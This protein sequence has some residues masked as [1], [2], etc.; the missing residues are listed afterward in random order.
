MTMTTMIAPVENA[1]VQEIERK[2]QKARE[3]FEMWRVYPLAERIRRIQLF[4]KEL[5]R[6]K[7]ELIQIL[8]KETGKP[9]AEI[10]T[11]EI[12]GSQL[13]LKYFLRNASR[14]LRDQPAVA[15][16][17]FFNKK[18]YVRYIPRGVIGIITPWNFPFIIP[19]GDS[20]PALIAG[21]AVILKPSE[22]TAQTA[23]FVERVFTSSGLFPEGLFQ[24]L[25]GDGRVGEQVVEKSDMIVFTG[26]TQSGKKVA[27][28]AAEQLKPFVLELGGKH[29]MIVLN[30][31]P[32]RRTVQA[33]VWGGL[34]NCG[35]L[36][37][38]V[39]RIFVEKEIAQPFVEMIR[40]EMKLLRQNLS[41]EETDL[42]RFIFP[43]Q[44]EV[45]Q[46]HLED[47]REKGAEVT[48][49]EVV[50]EQN[51]LM[52]PAVVFPAKPE[53]LVMQ[54]ETFGPVLPIMAVSSAEEAL[55]LSNSNPL[56]LAASIW[57]RDRSYAERLAYNL[58]AGLISIN[59]LLSHYV[60]CSLPFGGFKQSGFSRRHG[61]EGLRQF[62]QTQSVLI[63]D[64]P[65][66]AGEIWWFPYQKWKTRLVSFL[67]RLS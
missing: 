34:A 26:S 45:V 13:I 9:M 16:W 50:D 62:C 5:F 67:N 33:A 37:V 23:L 12:V 35:Q 11:M 14:I 43:G 54:E 20:L 1:S 51:F 48:G 42:G 29:P 18:A 15:P 19:L 63:H 58:E 39:E 36:C 56:G 31:A 10:Q 60:I 49:G 25:S 53:M 32:L 28:K 22:W 61:E 6:R 30:D 3:A 59:D 7:E 24:V 64:W 66:Q 40:K 4:W 38:G 2:F 52:K 46:K 57:T 65:A 55:Y 17:L 8:H 21:N 44:M 47:A 41:G 27:V